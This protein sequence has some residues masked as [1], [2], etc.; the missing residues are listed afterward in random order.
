MQKENRACQNCKQDFTIEPDDFSF[1]EKIKV[2]PPTFCPE[3][4]MM[5]R[6]AW[7]N[8][9][10]LYK[11]E[12][13]LC[14]K[15]LISMYADDGAPVY[16]SECFIGDDWDQFFYARNIDWSRD[17]FSQVIEI[18]R[19]Q[20]RV[21]QYR[22]GTVVNSDFGNSVVNTKNSYL[23]FSV[24][25]SE[26]VMYSENI[27]R[28][29]NSVDCFS[30]ADIDQCSWN[31]ISDKNYNSH[32]L[33]SS[34]SCIDSYFLYDCVN[35]QNCCLS[36]NLRNQQYVF[37]NQK[38]SKEEY[39]EAVKNLHLETFIGFQKNKELFLKIYTNAI[40]KYANILNSQNANGDY[41]LNSK[42][43]FRSFDVVNGSEDICYSSRIIKS[44]DLVDTYAI[45]TGE[46]VYESL[47]ASGN[48]YMQ[49]GSV[50][51]LSSKNMEYSLFCKNCSDCFG[52]VG[53]KNSQYYILNKKYSKEEYE[54]LLPKI[55]KLM[56]DVPTI[57]A[58]GRI[59]KYGEFFPFEFS[60]FGYNETVAMDYFSKNENEAIVQGFN[61]KIREKRDY[62]ITIRSSDLPD[63]INEVDEN[64]LNEVISCPNNGDQMTQCT[65][66]F[67][68]VPNELQFYR[69]KNL[70]L[71]RYCPNCRHYERLTYRNPM[72]LWQRKCMCE[73]A[74]AHHEGKCEV[75]FE[76]SYAPDR[77]EIVYCEKCYQQEVY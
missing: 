72:K 16:C 56:E 6:M 8:V 64:I 42:N 60:P 17:F 53:I 69:Q 25:D 58:K 35:C 43:V 26:D 31:I 71:P 21:Y 5:R 20:P 30:V 1:Y 49:I 41:I 24:V 50:L 77:P 12:C 37:N 23:C 62:Q 52:C 57:D 28:S 61:W 33:V 48:S 75:E 18:F 70:P 27:D 14:K 76:T 40:H 46:L 47:S 59:Y 32:F 3:C 39:A 22:I 63:D 73:K 54:E 13:G 34:H 7:R 65:S 9:R 74:H 4:R 55:K 15:V 19:K 51:C 44:K 2:P 67:K 68:I 29:K 10:S 11:R 36:T 66:A 45:L 38:L